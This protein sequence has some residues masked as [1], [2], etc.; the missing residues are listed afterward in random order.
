MPHE[1]LEAHGAVS[2]ETARAMAEGIVR[3]SGSDLGIGITGIAGPD[4]GTEQS[5][6]G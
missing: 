6:W 3:R 5:P 1:I 2:E 4:G